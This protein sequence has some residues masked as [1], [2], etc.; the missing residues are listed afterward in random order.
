MSAVLLNSEK[1][2]D[3][4]ES[5]QEYLDCFE[6]TI[7]NIAKGNFTIFE[8]KHKNPLRADFINLMNKK[9]F[10]H[11]MSKYSKYSGLNKIRT[12]ISYYKSKLKKMIKL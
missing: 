12:D 1:G 6:T 7:E 11:A 10:R 3:A 2:K 4:F 8:P 5:I 9:G